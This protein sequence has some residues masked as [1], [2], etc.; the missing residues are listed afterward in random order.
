MLHSMNTTKHSDNNS[1]DNF[2]ANPL[3]LAIGAA[4]ALTAT[5]GILFGYMAKYIGEGTRPWYWLTIAIF[6]VVATIISYVVAK[7]RD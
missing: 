7:A 3:G 2:K 4:L 1:A 6:F 5:F